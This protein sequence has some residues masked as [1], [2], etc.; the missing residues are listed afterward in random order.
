MLVTLRSLGTVTLVVLCLH[1]SV[2]EGVFFDTPI[3]KVLLQ[4]TLKIK[5][6]N[7]RERPKM[8]SDVPRQRSCAVC[9]RLVFPSMPSGCGATICGL[10]IFIDLMALA[11]NSYS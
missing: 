9:L 3:K 8:A 5:R 6:I 2:P 4:F 7:E 10:T 1:I 11:S